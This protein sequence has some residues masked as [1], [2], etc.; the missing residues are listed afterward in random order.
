MAKLYTSYKT[1]FPIDRNYD[2][3]AIRLEMWTTRLSTLIIC[4]LYGKVNLHGWADNRGRMHLINNDS[5][6]KENLFFEL[7]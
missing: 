5:F 3:V 1:Y 4:L 7:S 2:D 6:K